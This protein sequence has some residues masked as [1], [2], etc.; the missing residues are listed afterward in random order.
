MPS[1]SSVQS[2]LWT[3]LALWDTGWVTLVRHRA[4][5]VTGLGLTGSIE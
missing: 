5:H 1:M 2:K 3:D 4:A